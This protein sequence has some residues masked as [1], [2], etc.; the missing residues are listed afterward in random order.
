MPLTTE[1]IQAIGPESKVSL[2]PHV[3]LLELQYPVDELVLAVH[4][5]IS[6]SDIVSS[7]ATQRKPGSRRTL[8][9]VRQQRV[10]LAV[11]RFDDS[12]YYRRVERETLLLFRALRAG[13]SIAEAIAQ[14]FAKT[15]STDEEQAAL[16]RESF[17]HAS[18]LGWLCPPCEGGGE[19][20]DSAA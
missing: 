5:S 14:A 1:D 16:L 19:T 10:W 3:Q 9:A 2:Q 11:H 6:E 17:A 7:A 8:P 12:V 20:C 15:Q 4:R 13:A 18:E